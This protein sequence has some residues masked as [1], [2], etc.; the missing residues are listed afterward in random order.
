MKTI[1]L[2]L[3]GVLI[4]VVALAL[5]AGL[6]FAAQPTAASFGA[7]STGSTQAAGDEASNEGDEDVEVDE[8]TDEDADEDVEV[9]EVDGST[10]ETVDETTDETAGPDETVGEAGTNCLTDPTT[11]T[12][13]ELAAMSHG[14]IVCWAAHQTTWPPEF[15]NHG[16]WVS[17]WAHWGKDAA[18]AKAKGK[19][20]T[21]KIK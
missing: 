19:T 1:L 8:S 17:S 2:H 12:V 3:K 14:S 10:D 9:D 4:A 16:A 15:K 18:A 11:L 6:A 13:E 20:R 7:A 5:S 21:H